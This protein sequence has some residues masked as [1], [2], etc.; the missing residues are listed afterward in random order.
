MNYDLWSHLLR[1][2]RVMGT[3]QPQTREQF[4]TALAVPGY[5][6]SMECGLE[7]GFEKGWD[8]LENTPEELL[9]ASEFARRH[10]H[11]ELADA[12]AALASA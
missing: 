5:F 3:Y 6:E 11:T 2:F 7:D 12:V 9:A 8:E 10:G 4:E 1:P